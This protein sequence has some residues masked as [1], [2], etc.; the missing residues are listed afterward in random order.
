M[1]YPHP[2]RFKSRTPSVEEVMHVA[3]SI[4]DYNMRL[5]D[6]LCSPESTK[7][8]LKIKLAQREAEVFCVLFLDNK[9]R[10][11]AFEEM[12]H[13]TIDS[14]SVHPREVVRS[15]MKHNAAAVMLAHNHPSGSA[16]PSIA[17]KLITIRL[18]ESLALI[19]IKV[20]DHFVVGKGEIISFAQQGWI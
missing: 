19:E 9:H 11:I 7:T 12:F 2:I 6:V 3:E 20:L 1:N 15:A 8:Y 13:G 14:A 10:V 18:K 4:A 17:D 16:E 5:S